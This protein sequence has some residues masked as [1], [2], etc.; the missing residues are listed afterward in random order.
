[1]TDAP[2]SIALRLTVLKAEQRID[3]DDPGWDEALPP[4]RVREPSSNVFARDRPPTR[5]EVD[6]AIRKTF[7]TCLTAEAV[8]SL[9][10][11]LAL[12]VAQVVA[13]PEFAPVPPGGEYPTFDDERFSDQ[14]LVRAIERERDP[15]WRK[16]EQLAAQLLLRDVVAGLPAE[17]WAADD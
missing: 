7:A 12:V 16:D 4:V 3:L 11:P 17:L 13:R 9:R 10:P 1:M 6:R 8:S 15:L 14:F 2:F 5:E